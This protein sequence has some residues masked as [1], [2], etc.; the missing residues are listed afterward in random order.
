MLSK[1][2]V[3]FIFSEE[4]TTA[5]NI[6]FFI[7]AHNMGDAIIRAWEQY[8]TGMCKIIEY[9]QYA[10]HSYETISDKQEEKL[11]YVKVKKLCIQTDQKECRKSSDKPYRFGL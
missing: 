9:Y 7:P 8:I 5:E 4:G 1:Y 11:L 3:T 10:R 2:E 6:V